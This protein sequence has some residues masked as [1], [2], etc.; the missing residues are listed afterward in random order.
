MTRVLRVRAETWPLKHAS[1]A[2]GGGPTA[3]EVVVAEVAGEGFIGRGECT[4]SARHG[5]TVRG[6]V[7]Q[8]EI[9]AGA[10]SEGMGRQ[11][12]QDALPAGAARNAL[13]CALWDLESKI[14]GRRAWE[15]AG[16]QEPAPVPCARTLALDAP[17]AMARAAADLKEWP[18]L[19][20][21]LDS[22]NVVQRVRAVH[23]KA[24]GARLV[25]DARGAWSLATLAVMS[26][27]LSDLG[28]E[29]IEQPL[30]ASIEAQLESFISPVPL[31][32][33]DT[34]RGP[35]DLAMLRGRYQ[36]VDIRLDRTGGL[37]E[38]LHLASAADDAGLGIVLGGTVGTSLGMAPATLLGGVASV[39]DLD[40]PLR[41]ERDRDFGL[42]FTDGLVHPPEAAL[43]G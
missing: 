34:C 41:L 18:L 10:I 8:I 24:P 6:V 42:D 3:A 31:C 5:E 13:D 39:V 1:P 37:T 4:P 17:D 25:V 11:E 27:E 2:A 19:R 14:A 43:W 22:W 33:V 29:M 28:V 16:L 35:D 30:P 12:L 20:I 32:A 40:A 23:E 38:A 9:Q 7:A 26:I 36:M 21:E 15:L